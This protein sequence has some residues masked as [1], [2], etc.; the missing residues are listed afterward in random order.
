MKLRS[1]FVGDPDRAKLRYY[2]ARAKM[3][4]KYIVFR[5][6]WVNKILIIS[7]YNY[8]NIR[9]HLPR[10]KMLRKSAHD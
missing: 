9:T 8:V 1:K 3:T 4:K 6:V 10:Q 2:E 5:V 7:C